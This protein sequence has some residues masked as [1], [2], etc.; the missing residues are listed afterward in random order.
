M[1]LKGYLDA[2]AS[3]VVVEANMKKGHG[4][5]ATVNKLL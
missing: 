1:E 4:P 3:A 2:Q 5:V